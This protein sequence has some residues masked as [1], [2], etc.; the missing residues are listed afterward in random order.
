MAMAAA[1]IHPLFRALTPGSLFR[2]YRLLEQIGVGGE[3]V[4]WSALDE[5]QG[6]IHAIKFKDVPDGAEAEAEDIREGNQMEKLVKL[7]HA[8]ILHILK[9]GYE[10]H[11]R[12]TVSPYVPGGTLMQRIKMSPLSMDEIVRCATEI[13][14]ALD[15]LHSQGIIHRDLKSQNI[16]LDLRDNCY[17]TDFGLARMVSTSTVAFHTGHGT[18][19]YAS[20][21][22]IQ[23]RALTSRSDLYSFGILL[24]EMFTGQLPWNG[25]KQLSIEQLN[26]N[27]EL[28]D[29]REFNE[30]L[31]FVLADIL[32]RVTAA[33]PTLRPPSAIEI[34]RVIRRVFNMSTEVSL[35][36]KP[37]DGWKVRDADVEAML[38]HA[39]TQ[40]NATDG[41]YNLGLTK[42]A[43]VHMRRDKIN[44]KMYTDFLLSQSLTYAYNDDQWWQAVRDP[45][46]RLAISLKLL[47]KRNEGITGRIVTHLAGDPHIAALPTGLPENMTT[48]LLETGLKTDNAFLRRE[49]FDGLRAL[50]QPKNGWDGSSPLDADQ[51]TRLGVF[52]LE[53]S[54]FGDTTAELIGHLRSTTAVRVLLNH[55]DDERKIAALLLVQRAAGSLPAFV[56][57]D[58]RFKLTTEQIVQR[59]IQEPVSLVGAYVLAFLGAALGI[60]LQVYLTYHLPNFL[61]TARITTS[62]VRGLIAGS[63]FGLGIFI[64]RVVMERFRASPVPPRLLT[65]MFAGGIGMN[66]ALLIFHVLFLNTPPS[67]AVL[68]VACMLIAFAFSLGGLFRSRLP[69]MLIAIFA[70]FVA[71]LGTWWIHTKFASSIADLTP[72]FRYDQT[73]SLLQVAFT[74]FAVALPIGILGNLVNLTITEE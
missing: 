16:L 20:P 2:E 47:R 27:Q 32:R 71:I 1:H 45:R 43:L 39:F 61:D 33:D 62:L 3:G 44:T 37:V 36:R 72:I 7:Q 8:H 40:W 67:G 49:I 26:S 66:V 24:Y 5:D 21:E 4:V 57:G 60:A 54:E 17:L 34:M 55:S 42:F 29:P 31:P 69:G 53:D 70:V 9:Y 6:Q 30:N 41:T 23:S 15:Y 65:G 51:A 68:T 52:A 12:F 73:W 11:L 59:L 48:G 10:S 18:P 63:V 25:K 74:A 22:Q 46:Q 64:I 50:T 35:D 38:K 58:I 14:S 28:P 56:P 19:P 13:A